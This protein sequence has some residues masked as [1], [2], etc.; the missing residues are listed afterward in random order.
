M[1]E[2]VEVLTGGASAVYG[3]DAIAGVVNFIMKKD[4]EGVQIDGQYS[5]YQH[6]NDFGGPGAVELRDVIAGRAAT[7]PAQFAL[8]DDN[9]TDGN[10]VQGTITMGVSTE[11]GRG[12]ITAYRA[13]QDNKQILQRDRDFSACSLAANN[14]TTSFACGGSGTAFPGTFTD[15][16]CELHAVSGSGRHPRHAR[17]S[18]RTTQSAAGYN[19]TVDRHIG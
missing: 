8:P 17:R 16:G 2:R 4:F 13:Y 19:F 14:P 11:D 18:C 10:G 3:S 5:L 1:V 7:N 12:N 6:N 9:V 15:F